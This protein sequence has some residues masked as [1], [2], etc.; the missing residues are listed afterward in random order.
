[1]SECSGP[2]CT[3]PECDQPPVIKPDQF[4]GLRQVVAN[5]YATQVGRPITVEM[6]EKM[7]DDLLAQPLRSRYR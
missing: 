4:P 3:H 5:A 1:M 2:G 6:I 7:R